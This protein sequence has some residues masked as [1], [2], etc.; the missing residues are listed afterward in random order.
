MSIA[1]ATIPS[2]YKEFNGH[3]GWKYT[4]VN[5]LRIFLIGSP[6][7]GKSTFAAS[8][9]DAWVIDTEGRAR[10]VV[11]GRAAYFHCAEASDYMGLLAK[12]VEDGKAG[13]APCKHVVFD[14]IDAWVLQLVQFLTKT[15]LPADSR[16]DSIL[17]L[18]HGK[19]YS[20]LQDEISRRLSA[21]T[22]AGYGWTVVAHIKETAVTDE[23]GNILRYRKESNLFPSLRGPL[24]TMS[25]IQ[26]TVMRDVVTPMVVKEITTPKG[27]VIKKEV[28]GD[29][30][31]VFLLS[32]RPG[33]ARIEGERT[34]AKNPY[35]NYLDEVMELPVKD[36]WAAFSGKYAEAMERIKV[37]LQKENE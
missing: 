22:L 10:D 33:G 4:P 30:R 7:C 19:G 1:T 25:H 24:H 29:P 32:L 14:T 6:G 16:A 11:H 36:G 20:L 8:N 18:P 21:L 35:L 34:D 31:N 9:P 5:Q 37:D 28:Q 13:K 26:G 17:D 23:Q 15:R 12:L 2:S 27:K 3:V